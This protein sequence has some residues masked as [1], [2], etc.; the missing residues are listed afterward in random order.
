MKIVADSE[1]TIVRIPV[2]VKPIQIQLAP[3]AIVVEIRH[4]AVTVHHADRTIV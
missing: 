4:V 2:I 1:K 3:V